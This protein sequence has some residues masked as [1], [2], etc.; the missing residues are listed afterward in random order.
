MFTSKSA[1][2]PAIIK[3]PRGGRKMVIITIRIAETGFAIVDSCE[4]ANVEQVV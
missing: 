2:Q 3:T 4:L 1:P